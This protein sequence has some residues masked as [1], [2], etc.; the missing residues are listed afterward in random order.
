MGL[1]ANDYLGD[2]AMHQSDD[3]EF[4]K[5]EFMG[6]GRELVVEREI[7]TVQV[8]GKRKER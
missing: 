8:R 2:G 1:R 4:N 6:K 7:N 5:C 3:V